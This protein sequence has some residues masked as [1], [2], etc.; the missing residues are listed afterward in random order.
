MTVTPALVSRVSLERLMVLAREAG[1]AAMRHYGALDVVLYKA[2]ESPVTIADQAA[3][4]TIVRGLAAWC[5]EVPVISEEAESAPYEVR[6]HWTQFWLVDPLDGTKEFVSQNGEFTVN[7]ALVEEGVPVLGVVY[8]PAIDVMYAAGRGL[9]SWVHRGSDAPLRLLGPSAPGRDG[10]IVVESR[11]HPSAALERFLATL[12]VASRVQAGSSLKFGLVAE[13]SA[14][15]Y[16]RLGPTMEWDVAAG[17]CVYR[18]AVAEG[19]R[20]SPLVYNTPS[21]RNEGFVVGVTA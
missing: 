12:R 10:V 5:P 2:D 3:H 18:H 14:H 19:E 20:G 8:A 6:R 1:G 11:S 15:C 4:E 16:P 13:G 17:D 21:L 9:G 7:I